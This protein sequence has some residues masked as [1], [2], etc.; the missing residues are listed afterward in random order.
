MKSLTNEDIISTSTLF[1]IS[2]A[3]LKAVIEVESSGSGFYTAPGKWT[4]EIKV[5]FEGHHFRKYTKGIYD[6]KY[7]H[8]SYA[9]W[10]DGYKYA[11]PKEAEFGRFMEAVKLNKE[12]A[13]LSTSIG[14]FQIMCFNYRLCGYTSTTEM[15]LDFYRGEKEQL[16]AFLRFII[17]NKI[18]DDLRD[19]SWLTFAR[20]YNGSKNAVIYSER[21]QNSYNKWKPK[22]S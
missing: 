17:A 13:F 6:A 14:L 3:A 2:P 21:L 19:K 18:D 22:I 1:N 15:I 4:G 10:R 12:A 11:K 8:L 9:S 16:E 5:R 20:V 7:P